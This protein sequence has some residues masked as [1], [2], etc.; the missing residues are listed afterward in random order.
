[1]YPGKDG[2][3]MGIEQ[4]VSEIIHE[5]EAE[6]M[7]TQLIERVRKLPLPT[8]EDKESLVRVLEDVS[9]E[10]PC[11]EALWMAFWLGCGYQSIRGRTEL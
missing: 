4:E 10:L 1:M 8:P 5:H 11:Y 3:T 9:R 7:A 2:E 6:E